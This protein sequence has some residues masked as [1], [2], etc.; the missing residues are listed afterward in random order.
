M[1]RILIV[2]DEPLIALDLEDILK[3]AGHV[4]VGI[5][6][7]MR[8]ALELARRS[9]PFDLAVLDIDLVGSADGIETAERRR[10]RHGVEALFV[11]ARA[12]EEERA[13]AL[14]WK[15]IGFIGKPYLSVQVLKAIEQ[16]DPSR[17]PVE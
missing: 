7:S 5:A 8:D 13:R 2:E 9:A 16:V 6:R 12:E 17:L 14:D 11:S 4:V 3:D 15:P 1:L 10:S